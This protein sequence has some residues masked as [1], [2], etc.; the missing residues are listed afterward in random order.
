[1]VIVEGM[2]NSGKTTLVR[3][4]S[5]D[6]KLLV[7]NNRRRP[8]SR[9]D[10]IDYVDMVIPIANRFPVILDRFAPISE[11]IYGPI[12]RDSHL[13]TKDD[14]GQCLLKVARGQTSTGVLQ[15]NGS[16]ALIIYCRPRDST[17]LG[18]KDDIPQMEGVIENGQALL[19]A[20]DKSMKELGSFW[21]TVAHYDWEIDS[22]N[23]IKNL[24]SQHFQNHAN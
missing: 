4:L 6:C 23:S 3:A 15:G 20:Y 9:E 17:V 19:Q 16:M 11:P 21:F 22:Y 7:M 2:D 1:M 12:C 5:E 10:V 8:K 13:L 24:V 18:F 14:I